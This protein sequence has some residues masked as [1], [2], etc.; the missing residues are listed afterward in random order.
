M[1]LILTSLAVS[2]EKVTSLLREH[3]DLLRSYT[4]EHDIDKNTETITQNEAPS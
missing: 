3:E 4:I 2:S 1:L